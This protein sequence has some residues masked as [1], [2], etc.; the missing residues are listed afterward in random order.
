MKMK[1]CRKGVRLGFMSIRN[2]ESKRANNERPNVVNCWCKA[3]RTYRETHEQMLEVE[4]NVAGS[5][6]K[7]GEIRIDVNA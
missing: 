7:G 4:R 5:L 6:Q 1:V 2:W 3:S